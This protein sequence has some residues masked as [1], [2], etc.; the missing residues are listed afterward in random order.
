MQEVNK[1]PRH[2][3]FIMDGN[4]RWAKK[5]NKPRNFGHVKGADRVDEIVSACFE[6]GVECVSLYAFSTE[7]WQRPKEEVDKIIAILK[8]FLTVYI[9]KLI[10]NKIRIIFSGDV[11]VLPSD[12]YALILKDV[13]Q[14]AHFK[15]RTLNI[16]VNYGGRQEILKAVNE[17]INSNVN[18][19]SESEFSSH[20]YT[21]GLPDIDLVVR[22]SGEQRISNFFIWQ[23]AY[24][25]L[26]Y[27]DVLWPDFDTQE[28]DK[29]LTWY[30]LR[31]RRFGK[32]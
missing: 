24:S 25:E 28:L 22:T 15:D 18:S 10:K 29:A 27:T 4:G 19:V 23:I 5:Q 11:S 21:S 17:L 8:K 26:Y 2:I 20:L 13:E 6:R 32:I 12:V 14:T 16:A 1:T 3:G 30:S 7:N 31:N 9:N